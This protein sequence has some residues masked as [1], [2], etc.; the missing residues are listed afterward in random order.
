[1]SVVEIIVVEHRCIKRGPSFIG[2]KVAFHSLS[3]NQKQLLLP[4]I[5]IRSIADTA[6]QKGNMSE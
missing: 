1:M 3:L 5:L 6:I 2:G 4:D